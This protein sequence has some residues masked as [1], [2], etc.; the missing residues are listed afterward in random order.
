LYFVILI[1][2]SKNEKIKKVKTKITIVCG[3]FRTDK[4][5]DNDNENR[6]EGEEVHKY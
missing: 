3:C 6:I 2:C 1:A 4:I 5:R